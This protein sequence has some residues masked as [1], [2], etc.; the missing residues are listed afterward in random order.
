MVWHKSGASSASTNI[1]LPWRHRRLAAQCRRV[2]DRQP[3]P[4]L[5][6]HVIQAFSLFDRHRCC[7]VERHSCRTPI[8]IFFSVWPFFH[9]ACCAAVIATGG[10]RQRRPTSPAVMQ[11][12]SHSVRESGEKS[13]R[14]VWI[15]FIIIIIIFMNFFFFVFCFVFTLVQL[16]SIND[17]NCNP[18]L[19]IRCVKYAW[20]EKLLKKHC[21]RKNKESVWFFFFFF[22]FL[23]VKFVCCFS[24]LKT[25]HYSFSSQ[26]FVLNYIYND[27]ISDG[28]T[29]KLCLSC[30]SSATNTA[31]KKPARTLWVA[32]SV[33][34]K[35]KTSLLNWKFLFQFEN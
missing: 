15:C 5:N 20:K 35:K 27:D 28:R 34:K 26:F 17:F 2:R 31:P 16:V 11:S 7:F 22:L 9:F 14:K 23:C 21:W 4:P 30:V 33:A 6:P 25:N 12:T 18:I 8:R 3:S 29:L 24:P 10:M 1:E 19:K 13:L 32:L